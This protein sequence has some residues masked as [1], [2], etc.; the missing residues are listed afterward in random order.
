M[1]DR[2]F[3]KGAIEATK[4]ASVNDRPFQNRLLL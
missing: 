1:D 3:Q 4:V 2:P